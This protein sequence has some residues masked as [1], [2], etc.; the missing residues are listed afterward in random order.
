MP[1]RAEDPRDIKK[2]AFQ[3]EAIEKLIEY[4]NIHGFTNAQPLTPQMLQ[5][6]D[7]KLFVNVISFLLKSAIPNFSFEGNF[8]DE[9][10]TVL[11]QLGYPFSIQRGLLKSVGA[12]HAW[13]QILAALAWLVD[14]LQFMEA[15]AAAD[16]GE[17]HDGDEFDSERNSQ[18][19]FFDYC[20]EGYSLFLR[21]EDDLS[22][23]EENIAFKFEVKNSALRTDIASLS[24]ANGELSREHKGLTEGDSPLEAAKSSNADL[25]NDQHKLES[26]S[27]KLHEHRDKITS[28][29]EQEKTDLAS[30]TTE[31]AA[32]RAEIEGHKVT[33]AAQELTP[34]DVRRM[35]SEK[36]H[37]DSEL[38]ALGKQKDLLSKQLWEAELATSRVIDRL[39][40]SVQQANN[41]SLRLHLVPSGAKHANGCD[42]EIHLDKARLADEPS[43]LVLMQPHNTLQHALHRIKGAVGAEVNAAQDHVLE[44]E[45]GMSQREEHAGERAE[46]IASLKASLAKLEKEEKD[47]RDG[48]AAQLADRKA[49]T[50]RL[51]EQIKRAKSVNGQ[52]F[53]QSS[54]ELTALQKEYDEF[55]TNSAHARERMYEQLTSELDLLAQHKEM[56]ENELGGLKRHI[57]VKIDA[58]GGDEAVELA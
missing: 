54:A 29:L 44:A 19:M 11:K 1:G 57:S 3:R 16:D 9:V 13:P 26:H 52:D 43:G 45:Q 51:E 12:P 6:P 22:A 7:T 18:K 32:L 40:A 28:R 17:A 30:R 8:E 21:G 33:I 50:E 38:A 56:I 55:T 24:A 25:V 53:A 35:Y 58:L 14:L 39:D 47:V 42:H 49:E 5:A 20:H 2:K 31:L 48:N 10:P 15:K 27:A 23:L 34:A 37:L 41:C 36:D 4:L 46:E